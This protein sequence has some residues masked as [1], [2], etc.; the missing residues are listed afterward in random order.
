MSKWISL[1]SSPAFLASSIPFWESGGFFHPVQT[2]R[3]FQVDSPCRTN[4]KTAIKRVYQI[5]RS[6]SAKDRR[7]KISSP[8]ENPPIGNKRRKNIIKIPTPEIERYTAA[9]FSGK[10]SEKTLEQSRGG[11][12]IKLKIARR[13]LSWTIFVRIQ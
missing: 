10:I 11:M 8:K 12:G 9:S 7:L 13:R 2:P 6:F 1:R 4:A 5:P 3:A